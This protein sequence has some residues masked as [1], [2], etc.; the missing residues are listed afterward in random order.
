MPVEIVEIPIRLRIG[1]QFLE[2]GDTDTLEKYTAWFKE[3]Q[4]YAKTRLDELMAEGYEIVSEPLITEQ[5]IPRVVKERFQHT[6]LDKTT[7][8]CYVLR[9][10]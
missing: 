6:V 2:S 7:F 5:D 4:A 1:A 8:I 10:P 3:L 9:K